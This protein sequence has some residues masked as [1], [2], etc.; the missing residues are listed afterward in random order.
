MFRLWSTSAK[1]SRFSSVWVFEHDELRTVAS[2]I[3]PN[4]TAGKHCDKL[5]CI[6]LILKD[7][8]SRST[9]LSSSTTSA[10]YKYLQDINPAVGSNMGRL[11]LI[12]TV[13]E[14]AYRY[15]DH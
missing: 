4:F 11:R 7:F 10:V 14:E 9:L 1:L 6:N 15:M 2:R 12:S 3:S 8:D 13:F 5:S